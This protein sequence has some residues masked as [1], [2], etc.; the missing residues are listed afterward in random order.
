MCRWVG[1]LGGPIRPYEL[2]FEPERSLIEQSRAHTP[3]LPLPN[4]DGTGLGWYAYR[5]TPALFRSAAPAW[6]D[7]NLREIALEVETQ[8]FLAHVR[9]STGTPVQQTNCHPFRYDRWM[10]VHNGYVADLHLIRRELLVAVD[11][12]YF[13]NIL[14]TTDSELLFHLALTFGLRDDPLG[15]LE[16]MAG[17]VESVGRS[18]GIEMPL[19]M[20]VGVTDGEEMYAVRYATSGDVNTLYVSEDVETI[21]LLYPEAE[22]FDHLEHGARVVVSEPLG[23]L[24]GVWREVEPGTALHVTHQGLK[25]SDFRPQPP[26]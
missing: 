26:A 10:M 3:D 16:R 22:R 19:Q 20:T 7:E 12:H 9:A 24:P 21:R 5:R 13:E 6:S 2:L 18:K 4:G 23:D 14:G 1:Y 11:E 15:A 25:V 17:F 8:V